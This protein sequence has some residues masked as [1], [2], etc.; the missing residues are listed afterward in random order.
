MH[1]ALK[2]PNKVI[3]KLGDSRGRDFPGLW[4]RYWVS[5]YHK[6]F[7]PVKSENKYSNYNNKY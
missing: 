7:V 1:Q 3:I 2:C 6:E 5:N 4:R